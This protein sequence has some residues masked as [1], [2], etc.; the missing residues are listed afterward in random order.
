MNVFCLL[1]YVQAFNYKATYI[2]LLL[3]QRTELGHT[4]E[5]TRRADVDP[6]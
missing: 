3:V 2:L 6:V 4:D 5:I 1:T